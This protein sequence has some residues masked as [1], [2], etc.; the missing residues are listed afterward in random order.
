[1]IQSVASLVSTGTVLAVLVV[2]LLLGAS[3]SRAARVL[4][5]CAAIP[6]VLL[7]VRGL[8]PPLSGSVLQA[9]L[10]VYRDFGAAVLRGDDPYAHDMMVYPPTG[11]PLF[12]GL[13]AVPET[14]MRR[15][16]AVFNIAGGL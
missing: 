6:L 10:G 4:A 14:W 15:A 12:A 3:W 8:L 2:T 13:A 1:M 5:A 16:W 7:R 9:D 11:L